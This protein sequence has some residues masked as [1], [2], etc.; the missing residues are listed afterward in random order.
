MLGALIGDIVG[1]VYE[2]APIKTKN[3]EFIS[4]KS[5]ITDDSVLTL[6]TA[7]AILHGYGY[8]PVYKYWGRC[9]PRAGYG[10]NFYEWCMSDSDKKGTSYGNGSAMRVS[11]LGWACGTLKKARKEAQKSAEPSHNSPEG[12]KGAESVASAVF[13][14]RTGKSKDE[15]KEYI[16]KEF[17]YDLS[18]NLDDIREGYTHKQSCQESVPEALI[19]F[20]ESSDFEDAVA[21]AVSLGGDSDTQGCIA[22]AVAEAFYGSVSKRWVRMLNIL[23]P[24]DVFA[25]VE[26]FN[27]KYMDSRYNFFCCGR[28]SGEALPSQKELA[29]ELREADPTA[30]RWWVRDPEGEEEVW[31]FAEVAPDHRKGVNVFFCTD[32]G[33]IFDEL[34]FSSFEDA[35]LALNRNGFDL[36]FEN[37]AEGDDRERNFCPTPPGSRLRIERHP[38]FSAGIHWTP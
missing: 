4:A 27:K 26:E 8:M 7:D 18:R 33:V 14:A 22:G 21:N 32:G 9:Y 28:E 38:I 12:I 17:G 36:H 25:L 10:R 29:E 16:E 2:F 30:F 37:Y 15:I 5:R 6:A 35:F 23:L 24:R 20:L 34:C 31:A 3:F 11:P 19:A 1:S 13:L